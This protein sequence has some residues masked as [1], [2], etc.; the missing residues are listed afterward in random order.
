[1]KAVETTKLAASRMI[2]YGAVIAAISTPARLGPAT[3]AVETVVCSFAFPSTS[4]SRS[5]SDGR[6]DW[7]ATSKKTVKTPT[8]NEITSRCHICRR[9][10]AQS[11]GIAASKS[12]RAASP[13]IRIGLR[14][15]RSTQTP[16]GSAN[17]MNGRKPSTPSSENS[18]GLACS[19][20]AASHGIASAEICEPN[21]LIDWPV[22]SFR[23]SA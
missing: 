23:K 14:R 5:T 13:T 4:C 7:Y 11:S 15:S 19:S 2:A 9:S 18:N 10:S 1:M 3:C 12:A 20:T 17:R 16:A 21:S 6:Y 22:Q 8:T